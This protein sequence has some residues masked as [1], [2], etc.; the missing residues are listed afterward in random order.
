MLED[1]S[2]E[3]WIKLVFEPMETG[4]F[5]NEEWGIYHI[6]PMKIEAWD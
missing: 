1:F 4:G 5:I 6:E 3:N 2:H